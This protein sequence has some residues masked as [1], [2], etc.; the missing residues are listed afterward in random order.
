[1]QSLVDSDKGMMMM[2]L[3]ERSMGFDP[4]TDAAYEMCDML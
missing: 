2:Y 4:M 1:M 3:V